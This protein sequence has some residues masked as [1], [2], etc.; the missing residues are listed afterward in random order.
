MAQGAIVSIPDSHKDLLVGRV[1]PVLVTMMPDGQPQAQVVWADL[2]GDHVMI[3][4]E[5]SRQKSRNMERN[6]KVTLIWVDPDDPDRFIEIRG[7]IDSMTDADGV[8]MIERLAQKY[9]GTAYFGGRVA[10]SLRDVQRRVTVRVRP[11]RIVTRG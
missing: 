1:Y 10:E 4:T 9:D 11:T 8:E 2:D 7:V 5:R 3:N 6:P